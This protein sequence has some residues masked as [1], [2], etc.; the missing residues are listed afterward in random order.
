MTWELR[1]YHGVGQE[2][3]HAVHKLP[4][5][6]PH[7]AQHQ[8]TRAHEPLVPPLHRLQLLLHRFHAVSHCAGPSLGPSG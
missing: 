5:Y 4:G 2:V 6:A 3:E 8:H 1:A 7:G